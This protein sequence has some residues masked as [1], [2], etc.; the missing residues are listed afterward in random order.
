MKWLITFVVAAMAFAAAQELPEGE[1]KELIADRCSSCHSLE[2]VVKLNLDRNA[3]KE[4]VVKMVGYGAQMD[5]K[6]VDLAVDYL[7]KNFGIPVAAA[8]ERTAKKFIDGVCS[9]CHD[10]DLITTAKATKEEWLDIVKRMNAKG[11]GL[12][13]QD[14]EL[15]AGYLAKNYGKP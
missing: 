1:G 10:S 2:P 4:M 8:D 11:A 3:W 15:L 13:E 5:D 7:T 12:S 6:E 14:V 9:T